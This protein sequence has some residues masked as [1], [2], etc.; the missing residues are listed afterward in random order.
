MTLHLV[1]RA[2]IGVEV[3]TL[4]AFGAG[5]STGRNRFGHPPVCGFAMSKP[6]PLF[7]AASAALPVNDSRSIFAQWS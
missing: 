7:T 3:V 5:G 6:F 1:P 2:E 4:D